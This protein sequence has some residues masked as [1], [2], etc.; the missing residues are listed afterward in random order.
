MCVRVLDMLLLLHYTID[1]T[2]TFL[3][4]TSQLIHCLQVLPRGRPSDVNSSPPFLGRRAGTQL[5]TQ[6]R[7][8]FAGQVFRA[9]RSNVDDNDVRQQLRFA[10]Q[11]VDAAAVCAFKRLT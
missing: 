3:Y 7:I 8:E 10:K 5:P 9:V 1:H 2:D 4:Y 11:S 6:N